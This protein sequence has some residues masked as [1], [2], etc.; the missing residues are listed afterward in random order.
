MNLPF[1]ALQDDFDRF[2]HIALDDF[3]RFQHRMRNRKN[4]T[5]K[6]V[7]SGKYVMPKWDEK[8]FS[9]IKPDDLPLDKYL[10]KVRNNA[11]RHKI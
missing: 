1:T 6:P 4:E 2:Q 10:E 11:K 3:D 5:F 8:P 9:P 7:V